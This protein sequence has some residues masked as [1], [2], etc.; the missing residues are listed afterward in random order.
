[1]RGCLAFIA[2]ACMLFLFGFLGIALLSTLVS[3]H[4]DRKPKVPSV[5]EQRQ[6]QQKKEEDAAYAKM[7]KIEWACKDAVEASA[8]YGHEW[9]HWYSPSLTLYTAQPTPGFMLFLGQDVRFK[10]VYGVLVR[11]QYACLYDPV[12]GT[13]EAEVEERGL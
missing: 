7:K 5:A 10:N 4:D 12:T 8:R 3:R 13:V 6:A 11:M 1:M 9:E 2:K